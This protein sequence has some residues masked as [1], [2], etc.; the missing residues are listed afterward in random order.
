MADK[1]FGGQHQT[2]ALAINTDVQVLQDGSNNSTDGSGARLSALSAF[3]DWYSGYHGYVSLVVCISGVICN[4]LNVVVL[5]RPTMRN[6][7]NWIL[8][9]CRS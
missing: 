8:T 3:S 7:T 2:T 4:A 1:V 6:S 9:V 5:T